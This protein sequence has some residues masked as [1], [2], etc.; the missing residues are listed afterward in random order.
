MGLRVLGRG[1]MLGTV[2][3]LLG[4]SEASTGSLP[5]TETV[6]LLCAGKYETHSQGP[7]GWENV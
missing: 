6:R 7:H 5:T 3:G 2:I 1:T 4:L